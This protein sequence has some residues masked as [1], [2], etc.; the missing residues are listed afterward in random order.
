MSLSQ[1]ADVQA[2]QKNLEELI[3]NKMGEM[4]SQL[5]TA[6]L[7]KANTIA[8]LAEEFRCFRE[9][10]F[11]MLSLLRSQ[12]QDFSKI[13]DSLD[14]RS[15]RKALIFTGISENEVDCK[16][17]IVEKLHS[18][19][20]LKDITMDHITQCHRLGAPSKDRARPILVRFMK[21]DQKSA[22]WRAKQGLKG[23]S[24]AIKEFLTRTRQSVFS[25]AR[26]HF[27]M[28]ACWTQDGVIVIRTSDGSRHRISS[29]DELDP[30]LVRYP[31]VARESTV[32]ARGKAHK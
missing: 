20:A 10:V 8:K 29:S 9:L 30:L 18:K 21:V 6:S 11:G 19:L 28:R 12:I 23:S 25:K 3:L 2:S 31:K 17:F 16:A 1:L 22:V 32:A 4:E 13:V 14:M 15:R 24:I 26:L 7:P 27:G 5:Q